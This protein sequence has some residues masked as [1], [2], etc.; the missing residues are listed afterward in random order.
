[1]IVTE[2]TR[3]LAG[4]GDFVD[5]RA[6]VVSV[7]RDNQRG[8]NILVRIKVF[9][10]SITMV[11]TE[12]SLTLAGCGD[13]VDPRAVVMTARLTARKGRFPLQATDTRVVIDCA[14]GAGRGGIQIL[15]FNNFFIKGMRLLLNCHLCS[16]KLRV[17]L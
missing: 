13:F 16:T 14:L 3:T 4:C 2:R 17:A 12:R 8:Q 6:V 9:A 15:R 11:V 1:M 5:P 7:C 10:A